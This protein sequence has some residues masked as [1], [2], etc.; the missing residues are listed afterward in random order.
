MLKKIIK[1]VVIVLVVAF[2][3]IQF[4]R[5]DFTNPQENP[6]DTLEASAQVPADVDAILNRSCADCHSNR[7]V[8]PWYSKIAPSSWLLSS[9]IHEG[10]QELN[11]S[12]WNT[13]DT[14]KKVRK[15]G[16]ICDQV[17]K[18]DMPLYYY[19]WIHRN[20]RLNPGEVKM[21]C[22]WTDAEINRLQPQ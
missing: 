16:A 18:G 12:V 7:T 11:I 9:D 10:R 3:V 13:Y 20:A 8:Y 15:L 4:F 21:L 5:P 14:R 6:A 2:V 22:D 19:L 17:S 1:I